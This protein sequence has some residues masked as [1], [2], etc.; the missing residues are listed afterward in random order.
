MYQDIKNKIVELLGGLEYDKILLF[1]SRARGENRKDSDYDVI[2]VLKNELER[3]KLFEIENTIREAFAQDY[4]DIDIII[5]TSKEYE[6]L[7]DKI[8]SVVRYANADG[9]II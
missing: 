6:Y 2:V 8:G 3:K 4:I 1:G 9:I 5:K 7:K